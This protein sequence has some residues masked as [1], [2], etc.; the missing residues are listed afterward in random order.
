[1]YLPF[2]DGFQCVDIYILGREAECKTYCQQEENNSSY[3]HFVWFLFGTK[4]EK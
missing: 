4:I 1:V 2:I 3:I